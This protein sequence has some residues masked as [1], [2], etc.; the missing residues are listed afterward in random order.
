MYVFLAFLLVPIVEI[1]L[2]IQVGGLIGLW[3]TLAIVV[4]TA[5]LGSWLVRTQGRMALGEVQRTFSKLEDPTEPLAHGAMIV[6]AGLL[7]MT[8]GLFTDALGFALL[9]PAVRV[10]VFR[11]LR[12]RMTVASFH[13]GR[14]PRQGNFDGGEVIDGDFEEVSQPRDPNAPASGW[15]EGP[16]RR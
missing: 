5:V 14:G 12:A 2:F 15:V 6:L 4:G 8:P 7:L 10:A 1:A 11:H 3:P 9:V 13:A 16:D